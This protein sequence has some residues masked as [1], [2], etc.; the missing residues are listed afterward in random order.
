MTGIGKLILA[1][2]LIISATLGAA[3]YMWLTNS[4]PFQ[5]DRIREV[6]L[7][8]IRF[9]QTEAS[10]LDL[11][12]SEH[13]SISYNFF[14]N[15]VSVYIAY[16]ERDELVLHER[17][18]GIAVGTPD[19]LAGSLLWGITTEDGV[20]RELRVKSSI[21]FASSNIHFDFSEIDFHVGSMATGENITRDTNIEMNRRYVLHVWQ[22]GTIW[23]ADGDIFNS[24]RLRENEKSVILY[25]V[26]E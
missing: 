21:T 23:W 2:L 6:P 19:Q 22:S 25:V 12:F 1:A 17:I 8:H 4:G 18:G 24:I 11:L 14:G 3:G 9:N 15:E 5:G 7:G 16:Y 20:R 13:G 26:F 10:H